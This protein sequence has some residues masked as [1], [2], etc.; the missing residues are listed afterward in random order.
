M[1]PIEQSAEL[2]TEE[3]FI[4]Y[5][6]HLDR[7]KHV[8]QNY[9]QILEAEEEWFT[10]PDNKLTAL[11]AQ[12][13]YL[14]KYAHTYN[15]QYLEPLYFQSARKEA[16]IAW[17]KDLTLYEQAIFLKDIEPKTEFDSSTDMGRAYVFFERKLSELDLNEI[18]MA[19]MKIK[20]KNPL[21]S[22]NGLAKLV[23]LDLFGNE[24]ISQGTALYQQDFAN[25]MDTQYILKPQTL[26]QHAIELASLIAI[27]TERVTPVP[28]FTNNPPTI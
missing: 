25:K 22:D 23:L 6:K 24:L 2:R 15:P 19:Q 1:N 14:D 10:S 13:H 27:E 26:E 9:R 16:Q 28:P 18:G 3:D 7:I 12:R 5:F 8:E 4:N 20:V 21:M 11:A 17:E